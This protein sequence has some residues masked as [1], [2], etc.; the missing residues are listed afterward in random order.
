MKYWLLFIL[1]G[2]ISLSTLS[3]TCEAKDRGFFGNMK[4]LIFPPDDLYELRVKTEIDINKNTGVTTSKFLVKYDG[5]Y[6]YGVLLDN[7]TTDD[8]FGKKAKT[9]DLR[10]QLDFYENNQPIFSTESNVTAFLPFL[11]LRGNGLRLGS[12][13]TPEQVPLMKE[14]EC[15]VTVIAPDETLQSKYGPVWFYIKK[16][17]EK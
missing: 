16:Q 5:P 10:L 6:N 3:L 14:V 9:I 1:I 4:R 2:L 8:Y 15:K 7:L 13:E 11:G 12:F 17:S